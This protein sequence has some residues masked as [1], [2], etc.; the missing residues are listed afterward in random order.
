MPRYLFDT[1]GG[2]VVFSGRFVSVLRTY[3]GELGRVRLGIVQQTVTERCRDGSGVS[4]MRGP[5]NVPPVASIRSPVTQRASSEARNATTS[6]MSAGW[7]IRPSVDADA[8]RASSSGLT[9]IQAFGPVSVA[10][11]ATVFT[12][13]PRSPTAW[14][15]VLPSTLMAPLAIE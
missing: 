4:Y 8:V 11:G 10:P 9:C 14:A 6:A 12:V 1:L 13:M 15:S 3:V 5:R 7:P 2:K